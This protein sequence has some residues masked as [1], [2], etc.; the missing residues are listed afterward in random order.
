MLIITLPEKT[1]L[2]N[3]T[4]DD[5]NFDILEVKQKSENP[6]FYFFYD[7]NQQYWIDTFIL[8]DKSIVQKRVKIT[9]IRGEADNK[10]V[11]RFDFIIWDKSKQKQE[12]LFTTEHPLKAKVDLGGTGSRNLWKLIGFLSTIP[13]IEIDGFNSYSFFKSDEEIVKLIQSK[14]KEQQKNVLKSIIENFTTEEINNVLGRKRD[15]EEFRKMLIENCADETGKWQ[16]FF[17]RCKWIF[18]LSLD[19]KFLSKMKK[20]LKTGAG[21]E[22][23]KGQSYSDF[24][25]GQLNEYSVLVELKTPDAKIFMASEGDSSTWKINE[26]LA[27]SLVQLLSQKTAWVSN[28]NNKFPIDPKCLL[29]Y[30]NTDQIDDKEIKRKTFEMF[31]RDSRSVEIITYDELFRRAYYIVHQTKMPDNYLQNI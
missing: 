2:M 25:M 18:G 14:D 10:I 13:N 11:P 23:D 17:E 29:I 31:R 15:L 24:G 26:K 7:K 21:D 8:A 9:L 28:T 16:P 19:Y 22:E 4:F 20:E 27:N 12:E 5:V 1:N 3:I 6:N 30:G